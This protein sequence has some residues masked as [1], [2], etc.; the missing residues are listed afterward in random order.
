M[1][2]LAAACAAI[3]TI[4]P[5][6]GSA[7]VRAPAAGMLAQEAKAPQGVVLAMA[8]TK[9]QGPEMKPLLLVPLGGEASTEPA[10]GITVNVSR[11]QLVGKQ[12]SLRI[13]VSEATPPGL[14]ES[15]ITVDLPLD[16][17][18]RLQL[19]SDPARAWVL[20][21]TPRVTPADAKPVS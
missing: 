6:V 18:A 16:K 9:G 8:L 15:L 3:L 20:E 21:F 4:A 10:P 5:L 17:P 13:G 2:R 11:A 7:H 14:V 19:G 1:N 12:V